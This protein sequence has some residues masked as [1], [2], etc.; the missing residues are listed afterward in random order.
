MLRTERAV[1]LPT[2]ECES[3]RLVYFAID[4]KEQDRRMGR[5]HAARVLDCF[6]AAAPAQASGD[7]PISS[8]SAGPWAGSRREDSAVTH[9]SARWTISPT[10]MPKALIGASSFSPSLYRT[11]VADE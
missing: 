9:R 5:Q 4:L 3:G 7:T 2:A 1:R 10:G 6:C 11:G 8:S